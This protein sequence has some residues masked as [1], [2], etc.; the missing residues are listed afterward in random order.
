MKFHKHYF[1]ASPQPPSLSLSQKKKKFNTPF[2]FLLFQLVFVFF[3]S[4]EDIIACFQIKHSV[5]IT[6]ISEQKTVGFLFIKS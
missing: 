3:F 4:Y 1:K 5:Q 2:Q 6:C